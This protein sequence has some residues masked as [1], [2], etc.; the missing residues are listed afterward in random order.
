[1][2]ATQE[3]WDQVWT[4]H[5]V[6]RHHDTVIE[7]VLR[8][9]VTDALEV[10]AGSGR[11]VERL[12]ELGVRVVYSDFSRAAAEAFGSRCP[13]VAA[14]QADATRLPFPDGSFELVYSL[15]L[16][17]HFERSVR[18]RIIAEHFRVASRYVLIDV[19]QRFAPACLI[20]KAMMATGRWP[21][22]WETEYSLPGL[23][24]EVRSVVD[25]T[26]VTGSYGRELFPLPRNLKNKV[27][28][29]LPEQARQAYLGTHRWFAFGLAGALGVVFRVPE[30]SQSR[31]KAL[32]A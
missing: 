20:K 24:R 12:H 21:Y 11:D 31:P 13:Q 29:S 30:R 25:G 17:E 28:R 26:E 4:S 1:M 22:G 10:G 23:L 3:H 18:E 5:N 32:A 15:G 19:P 9:G 7:Q 16:L 8:L 2:N 6:S 27:Y 14:C